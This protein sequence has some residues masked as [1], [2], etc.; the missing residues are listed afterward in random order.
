MNGHPGGGLTTY[1]LVSGEV[2]CTKACL[3][4]PDLR[5]H[6]FFTGKAVSG[7]TSMRFIK[8]A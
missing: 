8:G 3:T 2:T 1:C 4:S 6:L 7:C 5:I